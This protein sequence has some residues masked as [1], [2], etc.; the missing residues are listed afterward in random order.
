MYLV[1]RCTFRNAFAYHVIRDAL[2]DMHLCH[3]IRDALLEMILF[4][5]IRDA[6]LEMHFRIT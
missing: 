5:V 1:Q 2:L 4:N 6:L 3:V